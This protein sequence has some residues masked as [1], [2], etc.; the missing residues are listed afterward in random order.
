MTLVYFHSLI[1]Y[2]VTVRLFSIKFIKLPR[3]THK[4]KQA[5]WCTATRYDSLYLGN[6]FTSLA[7]S[8]ALHHQTEEQLSCVLLTAQF[9]LCLSHEVICEL[10]NFPNVLFRS[11]LVYIII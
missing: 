7:T 10:Y 5:T 11:W 9:T 4:N 8:S 3:I 6:I 1:S 2:L